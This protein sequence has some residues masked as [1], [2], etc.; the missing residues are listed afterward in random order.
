M[1]DTKRYVVTIDQKT[2]LELGVISRLTNT[3]IRNIVEIALRKELDERVKDPK[4]KSSIE[5]MLG[6][7]S[8]S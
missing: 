2:H 5:K 7:N 6:K 4:I 1:D 3:K 8:E